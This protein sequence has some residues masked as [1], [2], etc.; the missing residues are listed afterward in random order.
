MK[1]PKTSEIC[2]DDTKRR[3]AIRATEGK[4]DGLNGIDYIDVSEDQRTLTVFFLL[5]APEQELQPGNVRIDGGR[6]VRNIKV[7]EVTFCRN[8][9][10]ERDDCMKVK[11]DKPGLNVRTNTVYYAEQ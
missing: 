3:Q 10:P 1:I 6:R 5:K 4:Q 2:R 8:E 11:V 7:L 9:D